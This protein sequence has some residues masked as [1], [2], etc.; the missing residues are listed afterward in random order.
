MDIQTVKKILGITT[1]KYDSYLDTVVPMFE[2]K[3]KQ[4]ANNRFVDDEGNETLP[5]DLQHTLAKWVQYDMTV[6]AGLKSKTMGEVSYT[7]DTDM[8]DFVKKDIA[9]YRRV[10][11]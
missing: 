4:R 8:P 9:P 10:R 1:T 7:F 11:F 2:E 5:L 3:I 6:K